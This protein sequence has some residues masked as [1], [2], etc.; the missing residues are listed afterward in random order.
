MIYSPIKIVFCAECGTQQSLPMLLS[1]I[2]DFQ[3]FPYANSISLRRSCYFPGPDRT[4]ANRE[5]SF[6]R[7]LSDWTRWPV[8]Q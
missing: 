2:S 4:S 1:V 8:L 3:M 5:L 6:C 7:S